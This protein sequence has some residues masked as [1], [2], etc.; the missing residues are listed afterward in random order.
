MGKIEDMRRLREEQFASAEKRRSAAPK[1]TAEAPPVA[2][3]APVAAKSVAKATH[4]EPGES[5]PARAPQ[6]KSPKAKSKSPIGGSKR[7]ASADAEGKCSVCGKVRPLGN[8]VISE[9]QKGFGKAC[10][11]SRKKPA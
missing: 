8:G 10:P 6:T 3:E 11:G 2:V 9:H 1:V 7:A 4:A 5:A